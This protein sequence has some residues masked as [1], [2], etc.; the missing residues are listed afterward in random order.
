M[1]RQT[2]L[3]GLF[4]VSWLA[5]PAPVWAQCC[6]VAISPAS[7]YKLAGAVFRGTVTAIRDYMRMPLVG[8]VL[9]Q[10]PG[11]AGHLFGRHVSFQVQESWKGV[12]TTTISIRT[13]QTGAGC[14]F[15]FEVG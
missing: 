6:Q 11:A 5:R 3:I 4:L 1:R 15:P 12:T 9:E 14:G 7:E 8:W 10:I 13:G 2:L